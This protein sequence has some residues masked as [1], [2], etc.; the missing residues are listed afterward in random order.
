MVRE[1]TQWHAGQVEP[2][3]RMGISNPYAA[4]EQRPGIGEEQRFMN[5]RDAVPYT[6]ERDYDEI[7]GR[8][9]R[10]P[11]DEYY[12]EDEYYENPGGYY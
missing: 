8:Y 3:R 7:R 12:S 1:P 11:E 2:P 10:R 5:P 9:M 6:P 4:A